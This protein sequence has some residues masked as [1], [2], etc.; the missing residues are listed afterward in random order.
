LAVDLFLVCFFLHCTTV[1]YS[2]TLNLYNHVSGNVLCHQINE[3]KM[4]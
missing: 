2:L 1:K 3:Q 4:S